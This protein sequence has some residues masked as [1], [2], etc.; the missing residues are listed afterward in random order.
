LQLLSTTHKQ[1]SDDVFLGE[2]YFWK[3]EYGASA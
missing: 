1:A 3:C 2:P